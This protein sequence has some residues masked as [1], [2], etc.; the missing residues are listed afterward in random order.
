MKNK[1]ANL[2]I[3]TL[4]VMSALPTLVGFYLM[5]SAIHSQDEIYRNRN[6]QSVFNETQTHLREFSK[7]QPD[8]EPEF[9]SLFEEIQDLK[10][11]YG[12]DSDFS[13]TLQSS[14]TKFFMIGFGATLA[15]ALLLGFLLSNSINRIYKDSYDKLIAATDKAKYLEDIAKW[16]EVAKKLVHEFRRPL[17][18]ILL[19][20]HNLKLSHKNKSSEE[21]GELLDE[22]AQSIDEEVAS[23]GKMVSEFAKFANLPQ[24]TPTKVNTKEFLERLVESYKS[25][26]K[27][28]E[29]KCEFSQE[30]EFAFFDPSIVR[31]CLANMVENAV[32]ANPGK[33]IEVV[34]S[35]AA[36][37]DSVRIGVTNTGVKIPKEIQSKIFE[38]YFSTK[39]DK[40]NM[41]LGLSIVR[42]SVLE[43]GGEVE[44][45]DY[46][47]GAK[48][49][50]SLPRSHR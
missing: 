37:P 48:F 28:V 43:Q 7:I 11:L 4:L 13:T 16:Q 26:W 6:V 40:N 44:C 10:M 46:D 50:I 36:A 41:G 18:P 19:W 39:T 27:T 32:E 3:S 2:L 33:R 9:Q 23:M 35:L 5:K 24:P 29:L 45:Y 31:Q 17:Q 21:F 47:Q 22:A 30:T 12:E 20:T 42:M 38:P 14:L 25:V 49:T 34:F 15:L 1:V 8:K